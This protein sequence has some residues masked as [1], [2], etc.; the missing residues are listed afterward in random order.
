MRT[1]GVVLLAF[2]L[3]G[4]GVAQGIPNLVQAEFSPPQV[5]LGVGETVQV[6]LR[7]SIAP[8]W[9][10]NSVQPNVPFLIPTELRLDAPSGMAVEVTWPPPERVL[11]PLSQEPLELYRGDLEVKLVLFGEEGLVAGAVSAVLRY[12][13]CDDE[14]CAPPA[15]LQLSLPV[16][17]RTAGSGRALPVTGTTPPG[18]LGRGLLWG[19]VFAFLLGLGLNLTPCVY[20][21]VPVTVAY[22]AGGVGRRL[23]PTLGLA[24]TYLF[25][26]ATTYSMLGVIASL[27]G[28][29]LGEALRHP[30]VPIALATLMVLLS[31][32]FFGVY[33]LRAPAGLLR[34]LPRGKGGPL[35]AFL[36][37]A[38]VGVVAAPCVGPAT[39]ALLSY[40]A[41]RADP[42][43]GFLLFFSLAMGLGL[44]YVALALASEKLARLPRSG[45]WTA[46]VERL[47]GL[48]L[49]GVALYL[50]APLL[51]DPGLRVGTSIL[52]LTG[53]IYLFW[54]GKGLGGRVFQLARVVV[55]LAGIGMATISLAPRPEGGLAWAPYQ[56]AHLA[57]TEAEDQP[58]LLY[59]SADW[60]LP[61]RKLTAT[62]FQDREV[63]ARLEALG[64][65]S[66]KAD[67]TWRGGEVED[68]R[69]RFSVSG[70][71]TLV[72]LRGGREVGRL[73]GY[74]S[75]PEFLEALSE[76]FPAPGDLSP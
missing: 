21:M 76:F 58:A 72:F 12:Q 47:L 63:L 30:G 35:T 11:L 39:V 27:G 9:H 32:S 69:E 52:S 70:V 10:I 50:V 4:G 46:W 56:P 1:L 73:V 62:T 74:V 14:V 23:L 45:P 17:V 13:A 53:G 38:I 57:Q 18:Q 26:I 7:I 61:C 19:I 28:G 42:F 44:P 41:S 49:M 65:V 3:A 55:L 33:T 64:I 71:P 24:L 34:R 25:G 36:M 40:V 31:L 75:P 66:I 51:P 15:E 8:S 6:A 2:G 48:G 5:Q 16:E 68:L 67:L 29:M 37:G 54:L 22:F 60:C 43:Q 59:F 20:P